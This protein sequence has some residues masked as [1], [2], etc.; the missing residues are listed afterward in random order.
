MKTSK[1]IAAYTILSGSKLTKMTGAEKVKVI[2]IINALKPYYTDYMDKLEEAR[3]R[4]KPEWYTEGKE[5]EW[6]YRGIY[7]DKL[8]G[9]EKDGIHDYLKNLDTC[10]KDDFEK[11][12]D[13]DYTHL[14]DDEFLKYAESNDFTAGQLTDLQDLI[15]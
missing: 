9:E 5:T 7:S 11:E 6:N 4:L 13:V 14:T 8:T 12:Q 10:M 1:I 15:A 3:K 2:K